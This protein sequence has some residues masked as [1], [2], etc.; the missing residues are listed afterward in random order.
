L[1]RSFGISENPSIW[2]EQRSGGAYVPRRARN[3][4]GA[5]KSKRC[6]IPAG[7]VYE[8][9]L[10]ESDEIFMLGDTPFSFAGISAHD[11]LGVTSR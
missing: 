7:G 11:R 9:T 4:S 6:L 5:F 2:A 1:A 3:A 10:S 8:G